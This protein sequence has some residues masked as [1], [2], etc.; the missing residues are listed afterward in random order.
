MLSITD[1]ADPD[2]S[3]FFALSVE[4]SSRLLSSAFSLEPRSSLLLLS[5]VSETLQSKVPL[6]F[7]DS[8]RDDLLRR[9]HC[10][11]TAQF[12]VQHSNKISCFQQRDWGERNVSELIQIAQEKQRDIETFLDKTDGDGQQPCPMTV[13]QV[14]MSADTGILDHVRS[15]RFF[16]PDWDGCGLR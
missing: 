11:S 4:Q 14:T 9:T 2:G 7:S 5:A 12:E 15:Q 1:S 6:S 8:Q 3:A 16:S 13:E 10:T